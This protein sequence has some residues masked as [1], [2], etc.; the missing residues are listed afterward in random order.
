MTKKQKLIIGSGVA[1]IVVIVSFLYRQSGVQSPVAPQGT[2]TTTLQAPSD[3]ASI[4]AGPMSV[5]DVAKDISDEIDQ[6]KTVFE[7]ETGDNA[8]LDEESQALNDID[9]TYDQNQF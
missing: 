9:Q 5:D 8:S 7:E 6:D 1:V 2:T 4:P 3:A